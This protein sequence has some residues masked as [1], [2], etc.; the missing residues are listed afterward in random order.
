MGDE[1]KRGD[2]HQQARTADLPSRKGPCEI[3]KCKGEVRYFVA[4][5]LPRHVQLCDEDY[6]K[7][8]GELEK[9]LVKILREMRLL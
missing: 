9:A 8:R 4:A 5:K 7:I 6:I 2:V 3:C 1:I